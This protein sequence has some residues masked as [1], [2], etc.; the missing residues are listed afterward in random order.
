M[1][2]WLGGTSG[3][4]GEVKEI[5]VKEEGAEVEEGGDGGGGGG[6]SG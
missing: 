6:W 5:V 3:G 1:E 4:E 2:K